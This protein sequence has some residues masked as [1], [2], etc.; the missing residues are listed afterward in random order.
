ME[1]LE[2]A[3]GAALGAEV[4][5]AERVPGGDLNEAWRM[6]LRGDGVPEWVFVKTAADAPDGGYAAEAAGLT[7]LGAAPGAPAVPD[8]LHVEDR[9]TVRFLVLA[10]IE[11]DRSTELD[12][13]LLGRGLAALHGAGA[14]AHGSG[15]TL[16]IGPLT[17][18][19]PPTDTWAE[20]YA[21]QRLRP[22]IE[23][24]RTAENLPPTD[25][26]TIER[27]CARL[28]ELAGPIEPPARLHGDLWAGNVV[29]GAGGRP[30]LVDPA[31]HGGHR[32][33]D[34]AMLRLFG[35]PGQRCFDAYREAAPLADG[36]EERV[37]LWQL[38]PLLVH[39]V[40]FGGSYGSRAGELAAR[41]S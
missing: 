22:L 18:P 21:E 34:L 28:P 23:H 2:Q 37:G 19:D 36:W 39:T 27:V 6:R 30:W 16:H 15:E 20:C 1:R 31:A 7:W 32:E 38:F 17:L 14:P 11:P 9:G 41:Y 10:W 25:A 24:A 5:A 12:E 8:V 3:I 33:V 13:E 35:G 40:L 4:V 29:T 26:A